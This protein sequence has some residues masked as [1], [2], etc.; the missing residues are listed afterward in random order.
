MDVLNLCLGVGEGD[1][2]VG[3]RDNHLL[4]NVKAETADSSHMVSR[5]PN[6]TATLNIYIR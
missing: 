4:I 5:H 2:D 1:V 6:T 3:Y